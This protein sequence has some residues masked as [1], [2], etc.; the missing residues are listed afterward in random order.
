ML[1]TTVPA[2]VHIGKHYMLLIIVVLLEFIKSENSNSHNACEI[3]EKN[4][5]KQTGYCRSHILCRV[6]NNIWIVTSKLNIWYSKS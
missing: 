1:L 5:W 4:I 6:Y 2:W 3:F